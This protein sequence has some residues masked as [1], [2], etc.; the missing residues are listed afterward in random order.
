MA[1]GQHK[2]FQEFIEEDNRAPRDD[3]KRRDLA[4]AYRYYYYVQVKKLRFIDVLDALSV[5]F[6]ISPVRITDI[7]QREVYDEMS[8]I[9]RRRPEL[10]ELKEKYPHTAW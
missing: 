3:K 7:L 5:E 6:Y 10:K 4:L 9:M 1:R 8:S 2:L